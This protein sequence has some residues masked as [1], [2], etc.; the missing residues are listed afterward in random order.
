MVQLFSKLVTPKAQFPQ[1][2]GRILLSR[3]QRL[4][5]LHAPA[6]SQI[7]KRD[8]TARERHA[9]S[10]TVV[11]IEHADAA[12]QAFASKWY[13]HGFALARRCWKQS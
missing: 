5:S 9:S 12:V 1:H 8:E 2:S 3:Y 4:R 6:G 10:Y 11:A 13:P 7:Y